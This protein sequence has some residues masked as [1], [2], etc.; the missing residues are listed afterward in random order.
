MFVIDDVLS[1]FLFLQIAFCKRHDGGV[2]K[3]CSHAYPKQALGKT[4]SVLHPQLPCRMLLLKRAAARNFATCSTDAY[5]F[6][7]FCKA[8]LSQN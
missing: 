5:I 1:D 7:K 2:L 4:S 3:N 8:L 6:V